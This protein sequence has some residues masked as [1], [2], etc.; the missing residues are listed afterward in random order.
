MYPLGTYSGESECLHCQRELFKSFSMSYD[1]MHIL[2]AKYLLLFQVS[3]FFFFNLF[4][5]FQI[6]SNGGSRITPVKQGKESCPIETPLFISSQLGGHPCT[7]GDS[8]QTSPGRNSWGLSLQQQTRDRVPPINRSHPGYQGKC[9]STRGLSFNSVFPHKRPV[10]TTP[11]DD[12]SKILGELWED[13][14]TNISRRLLCVNFHPLPLECQTNKIGSDR[15]PQLES[16][17]N[18]LS[19]DISPE[20]KIG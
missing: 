4:K 6:K 11:L 16:K 18:A 13:V 5:K 15:T 3:F 1:Q 12:L 20:G 8:T 14:S 9:P 19:Q 10:L 2:V 17:S 7:K